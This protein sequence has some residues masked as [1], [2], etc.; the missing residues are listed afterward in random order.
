MG[1]KLLLILGPTVYALFLISGLVANYQAPRLPARFVWKND[2]WQVS[3]GVST[4]QAGD[5]LTELGGELTFLTLLVD[6]AFLSD[7]QQFLDWQREKARLHQ[8]LSSRQSITAQVV[9]DGRER[10][11]EVPI[12]SRSW[13]FLQNS[14]LVHL[15][16]SLVFLLVG[17]STFSRSK[18]NPQAFW[19]YLLCVSMSL[20]YLSNVI[21]LLSNPVLE[22]TIF[23]LTN[24]VNA[25]NFVLGPALLV[26]FSLLMPRDRTRPWF[27][28][29]LYGVA[30]WSVFTLNIPAHGVLVPSFFLGSLLAILQGA[31]TSRGLIQKQ[32][33]K[34]VGVGFLL[35]L[36]PW[37]LLNGLPLLVTGQRLMSDTFPG[38]CLAFIPIFMGVAVQRYRLFDVSSFLES[39]ALYLASLGLLIGIDVTLL[40]LSGFAPTESHLLSL[41][42]VVGLYGPVRARLGNFLS[43]LGHRSRTSQEDALL[44]LNQQ[45]ESVPLEQ[46]PEALQ[47]TVQT[48]YAPRFFQRVDSPEQAPGAH[49][50]VGDSLSVLLVLGPETAIRCGPPATSGHYNSR[51]MEILEILT[52]HCHLTYR[53]AYHFRQAENERVRRLEDK[54]RLL[55]DLH[56][57]VGA[58]LA[59]IRL[60]TRE[61]QTARLAGDALFELQ[62]FLYHGP[63]YTLS[64]A[65][66]VAEL[67]RYARDTLEENEIEVLFE[68]SGMDQLSLNRSRAL[69]LF[70]LLKEALTNAL[71]H[72]G[73]TKVEISLKASEQLA[74]S[75]RDNGRG[76][77]RESEGRGLKGMKKRAQELGGEMT[78][79]SNNGVA[80]EFHLPI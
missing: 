26:H 45:L 16:V 36:G 28:V 51:Q 4:F 23:W 19:F 67:R 14:A 80:L 34:W 64:G 13:G 77:Q 39:T 18:E 66:F 53:A 10:P 73:A 78:C 6:N 43:R 1:K 62:S 74:L 29:V 31:I 61:E 59:S 47:A 32:Q 17:W 21:S 52:R 46:I 72:S 79:Q 22:P 42:L 37:I 20:V 70:R 41:A 63:D 2:A 38:A 76:I 11:V 49:L 30:L 58:A 68:S 12:V 65:D 35:G 56:D 71:K 69:S 44:L 55:G 27:L 75:I 9:R 33:M 48:L 54:E 24:L 60:G 50:E 7:R 40:S 5:R 25:F 8:E 3:E 15:P 57:G